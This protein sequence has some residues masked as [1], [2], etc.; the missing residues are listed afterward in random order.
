MISETIVSYSSCVCILQCSK[1]LQITGLF[2]AL[3]ANSTS[4]QNDGPNFLFDGPLISCHTIQPHPD[5]KTISGYCE[6]LRGTIATKQTEDSVSPIRLTLC[7]PHPDIA[8]CFCCRELPLIKPYVEIDLL[9]SPQGIRCRSPT[10]P[11]ALP[12]VSE[13]G[14]R[15]R[16]TPIFVPGIV[17]RLHLLRVIIQVEIRP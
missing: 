4:F 6:I 17:P 14:I 5:P 1:P 12:H 3:L 10:G 2:I 9:P 8:L 13:P 16:F 11:Y 15:N 7:A